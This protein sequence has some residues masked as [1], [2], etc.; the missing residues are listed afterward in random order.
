MLRVMIIQLPTTIN[1]P[2]TINSQLI[3]NHSSNVAKTYPDNQT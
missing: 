2:L 1:Q 3:N